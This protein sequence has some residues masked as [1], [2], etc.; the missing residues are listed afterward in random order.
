MTPAT[1]QQTVFLVKG[2]RRIR[3]VTADILVCDKMTWA[4]I[5][6]RRFLLGT[7]AFF[8]R[9]SAEV[10]KLGELRKLAKVYG[11]SWS[12]Q[13]IVAAAR[14]QLREYEATGQLQ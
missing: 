11:G 6:T 2:T 14:D 5:G 3:P 1:K 7:S 12:F 10:R 9:K 13:R 4:R 8:T